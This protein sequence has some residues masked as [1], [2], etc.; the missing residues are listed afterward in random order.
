MNM[1]LKHKL[2]SILSQEKKKT[3]E[4]HAINFDRILEIDDDDGFLDPR[5][6]WSQVLVRKNQTGLLLTG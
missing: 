1:R 3:K 5:E 4:S 6:H 2:L